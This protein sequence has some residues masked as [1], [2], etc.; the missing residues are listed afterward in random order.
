[1]VI[2]LG[3]PGAGKSLQGHMLSEKYGWKWLSVGSIFREKKSSPYSKMM[4]EGEL[5]PSEVTYRVLSDCFESNDMDKVILD[6]FPRS[7]EQADWLIG[8]NYK[9]QVK[10]VM[11]F[12]AS[13][14]EILKRL[15]LRG[16]ADDTIK[17]IDERV[18]IYE[19]SIEDILQVLDNAK[20]PTVFING[21]GKVDRIYNKLVDEL[22]KKELI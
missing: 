8:S 12:K 6:G 16:R 5:I 21:E 1:M 13:R 2:F 10:L 14:E 20:M 9:S 11:V 22:S 7:K 19:N 3:P 4:L 18:K 15:K 17:A